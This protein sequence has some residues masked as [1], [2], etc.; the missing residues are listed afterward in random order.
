MI[1]S[2]PEILQ[3]GWGDF[4][5]PYDYRLK[6]TFDDLNHQVLPQLASQ[7]QQLDQMW[8]AMVL[9]LMVELELKRKMRNWFQVRFLLCANNFSFMSPFLRMSS[10]LVAIESE[11]LS[12]KKVKLLSFSGKLATWSFLTKKLSKQS[13]SHNSTMSQRNSPEIIRTP[14]SPLGG[15]IPIRIENGRIFFYAIGLSG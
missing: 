15:Q 6:S 10:C 8:E 5:Y 4:R 11:F 7:L 13:G 14:E 3:L 9:G 12:E 1:L 2:N